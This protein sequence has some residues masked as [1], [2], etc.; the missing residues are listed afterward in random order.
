MIR[1]IHKPVMLEEVIS[2]IPKEKKLNIIDATFG[3]GGYSKLL[4][5]NFEIKNLIAIDRDPMTKSFSNSIKKKFPKKFNLINGCFSNIDNLIKEFY[6]DKKNIFF[7]AIIFDLGLSSNQLEDSN[8]GFSFL[9]D[10]PLDMNMGSSNILASDI[11][12][13]YTEKQRYFDFDKLKKNLFI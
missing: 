4:L 12:N 5:E 13:K 1:N 2:F 9:R 3:G 7:D 8:R 6:D 11:I 10:N